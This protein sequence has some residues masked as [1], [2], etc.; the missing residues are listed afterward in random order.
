MTL[1]FDAGDTGTHLGHSCDKTWDLSR[2]H[3]S[4]GEAGTSRYAGDE[5]VVRR[6]AGGQRCQ[7]LGAEGR[8]RGDQGGLIAEPGERVV[9]ADQVLVVAVVA[10]LA[11]RRRPKIGSDTNFV[12]WLLDR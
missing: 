9:A 12:T 7:L 5:R 1:D 2:A 6:R 3:G 4:V 8:R 10:L 11:P